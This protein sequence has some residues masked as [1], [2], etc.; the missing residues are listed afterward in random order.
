VGQNVKRTGGRPSRAEASRLPDKIMD[1]AA[2]LF[3]TEGYGITSIEAIAKKAG[4]SKRTFYDRFP[5]KADIF[6]AVVH[7]LIE[8][9]RPKEARS[10]YE[11]TNLEDVLKH[12]AELMLHAS[13]TKQ[14]L[15]LHRVLLAEALRFPE[16]AL[17]LNEQGA[18]KEAVTRIAQLLK[19]HDPKASEPKT[20]AAEQ[21]IQ[22][23]VSLP[24]RRALGLG[25]PMTGPEL[26][27]W[28]DDTVHLFL[29]G[30][31]S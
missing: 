16:L 18:R 24:Q 5:T 21:F 8:Q 19:A 23:V 17:I 7:R 26:K 11:G 22:M 1:A 13:L 12:I 3:F 4:V 30:W 15:A 31:R 20:F 29:K 9:L 2:H 27:K 14:A 10:P 28:V 25:K 6:K